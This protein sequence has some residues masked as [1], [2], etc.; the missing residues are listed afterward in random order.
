[1]Q[2]K[3]W[4]WRVVDAGGLQQRWQPVH[5]VHTAGDVAAGGVGDQRPRHQCRQAH[6]A[7]IQAVLATAE[8]PVGGTDCKLGGDAMASGQCVWQ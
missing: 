8:R 4:R 2:L 5:V 6:T 7:F 3:P 1:M